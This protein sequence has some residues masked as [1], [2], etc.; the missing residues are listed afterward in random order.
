MKLI[1]GSDDPNY[2]K[3]ARQREAIA[4]S[5][6]EMIEKSLT[7]SPVCLDENCIADVLCFEHAHR[8]VSM[9]T[10]QHLSNLY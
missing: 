4:L 10:F 5:Q 1:L 3:R 2:L 9:K 6:A 7:K 8:V